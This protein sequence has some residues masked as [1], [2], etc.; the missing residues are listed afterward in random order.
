MEAVRSRGGVLSLEDLA[1]HATSFPE[2]VATTF[3]DAVT[4][5]ELPPPNHGVAALLAMN[6]FEAFTATTDATTEIARA[7]AA[8]E[9]MRVSQPSEWQARQQ[10]FDKKQK[11]LVE[12]AVVG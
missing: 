3:R 2:P 12:E 8:V 10:S 7:H 6:V 9:A 11:Q 5:W 4:V 1:T